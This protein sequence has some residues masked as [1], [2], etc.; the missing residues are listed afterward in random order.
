MFTIHREPKTDKF[1]QPNGEFAYDV[2]N[3]FEAEKPIILSVSK[4]NKEKDTLGCMVKFAKAGKRFWLDL[5]D[6]VSNLIK[7]GKQ[8]LASQIY[9]AKTNELL[10]NV[11]VGFTAGKVTVLPC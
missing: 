5:D 1:R 7:A 2:K 4:P 9:D 11:K 3:T 10:L 6:L 8:E